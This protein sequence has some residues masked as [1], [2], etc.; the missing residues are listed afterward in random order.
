MEDRINITGIQ[1]KKYQVRKAKRTIDELCMK[2]RG[3]SV[4][5]S[6]Y[7][8]NLLLDK[9]ASI[10]T[11][12]LNETKASLRSQGK[13]MMT[14]RGREDAHITT[15]GKHQQQ[16]AD[17]AAQIA[18]ALGLNVYLARLQAEH[19]DDG[20]TF[21]GH[22]GERV[23][24]LIGQ[25]NNCGYT[26]HN[27][28]SVDML[29]SENVIEK[30]KNA[31]RIEDPEVTEETLNEVENE[32]VTYVF[33][34]ILAHNGEGV[35]REIRPNFDKTRE[36]VIKEKNNCY[37]IK[38]YDKKIK[39]TTMEGAILRFADIIAYTRT[40]ILD[41]FR[42]KLISD[43]DEEGVKNGKPLEKGKTDDYYAGY[44]KVIGTILSY[45]DK[46]EGKE[47]EL[48]IDEEN[49]LEVG[50]KNAKRALAK[51]EESKTKKE[52]E[53]REAKENS[54]DIVDI[55][56]EKENLYKKKQEEEGK[57]AEYVNAQKIYE[58]KKIEIARQYL[59]SIPKEQRK[60]EVV[61]L[62]KNVFIKDLEEYSKDREYIGFSPAIGEALFQLRTYNLNYIVKYTRREFEKNKLLNSTSLLV[63]RLAKTLID[64]GIIYEKAFS[65]KMKNRVNYTKNSEKCMLTR[66]KIED[67]KKTEKDEYKYDRKVFHR[68]GKLFENNK[69]RIAEICTNAME[70]IDDIAKHDLNIIEE[71]EQFEVPESHSEN[72]TKT[73][74]EKYQEKLERIR[75]LIQ[76]KS[77]DGVY[78]SEIEKLNIIKKDT[79]KNM[80]Q[81][82]AYALA[83]EYVEG[84]S[85]DTIIDALEHTGIITKQEAEEVR[86]RESIANVT[87]DQSTQKLGDSWEQ[88]NKE[89]DRSTS[90]DR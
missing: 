9:Y 20:H 80:E 84:M 85:D 89:S 40:D 63:D 83:K 50:I 55:R 12:V 45:K 11:R 76:E 61:D 16:V 27:A 41:G 39:P 57:L 88:A 19:H 79:Q 49:R 22:A 31:I 56:K 42:L 73:V 70:S 44:L 66:K 78:L 77:Q 52:T 62:M 2:N 65:D 28:L 90:E 32:I 43:F 33:D 17:I 7:K 82:Y 25:L 59:K 6:R 4:Y 3:K 23:M 10:I 51:I 29:N 1:K 46:L 47:S 38:A 35:D 48:N 13:S 53:L 36:D 5:I 30:I 74:Y 8:K 60:D 26:V 21:N 75:K 86:N 72:G 15:R 87:I 68:C 64:T 34:G 69:E 14:P 58:A 67:S 37:Q 71:N 24:N 18:E 54:Q 81:I